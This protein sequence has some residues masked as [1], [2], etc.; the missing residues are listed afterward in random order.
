MHQI[1]NLIPT[2]LLFLT[3]ISDIYRLFWGDKKRVKISVK[4]FSFV[5]GFFLYF[6][7]FLNAGIQATII[8]IDKEVK[9][10]LGFW[11]ALPVLPISYFLTKKYY[12]HSYSFPKKLKSPV[13]Y[14]VFLHNFV[15]STGSII[16]FIIAAIFL[17]IVKSILY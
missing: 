7:F 6:I 2:F 11:V 3:S 5:G 16:L 4:T 9:N 15:Y 17:I 14:Q 10:G 1:T 13:S 12:L 8:L